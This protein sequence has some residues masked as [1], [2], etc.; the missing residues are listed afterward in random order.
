MK[1]TM[2]LATAMIALSGCTDS[3]RANLG[4]LG[5]EATVTCYSGGAVVFRATSTG[6]VTTNRSGGLIFKSRDTG[7]F[8]HAYADC[9]VTTN[10]G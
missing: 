6:K 2:I 4:A 3:Q 10:A 9:I 5:E 1:R 7:G 8:V